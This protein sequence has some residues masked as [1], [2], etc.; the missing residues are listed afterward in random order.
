MQG[1]GRLLVLLFVYNAVR[2]AHTEY[3]LPKV[4]IN[5]C[6]VMIHER[7][8]FDQ[9]VKIDLKTN[10]N[11]RKITTGQGD[12]YTNVLLDYNYFK[13][14]YKIILDLSKQKPLDADQ[15]TIHQINFTRNLDGNTT[16]FIYEEVKEIF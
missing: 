5:N 3:F 12:D 9:P 4:K 13:K 2:T 6:N 15:K 8:L 11:I 7:S 16:F 1:V 10:D 14:Y